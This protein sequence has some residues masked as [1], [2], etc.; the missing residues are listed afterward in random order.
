[1]KNL[2]S[3]RILDLE[4]WHIFV[5]TEQFFKTIFFKF[6]FS[7]KNMIINNLHTY[8]WQLKYLE[9]ISW[10]IDNYCITQ[11]SKGIFQHA[12]KTV[13][14]MTLRMYKTIYQRS[15]EDIGTYT[16]LLPLLPPPVASPAPHVQAYAHSG[17]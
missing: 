5:I 13:Y 11:G 12:Y 17:V 15:N 10:S 7:Y 4:V 14:L 3:W 6:A 9:G 8:I 1:M 16:A 2:S